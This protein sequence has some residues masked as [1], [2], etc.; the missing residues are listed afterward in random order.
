M[1]RE[2]SW[3]LQWAMR[4]WGLEQYNTN[5]GRNLIAVASQ[6]QPGG[7]IKSLSPF[8]F[9]IRN[10]LMAKLH[11]FVILFF[12]E[13]SEMF[14]QVHDKLF[15]PELALPSS[16]W[17]LWRLKTKFTIQ[18]CFT[19]KYFDIKNIMT[20]QIVIRVILKVKD[21]HLT[22]SLVWIEW[23]SES[24]GK[25]D[26]YLE[27]YNKRSK[28]LNHNK[29]N[30]PPTTKQLQKW[31]TSSVL[32]NQKLIQSGAPEKVVGW[33]KVHRQRNFNTVNIPTQQ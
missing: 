13:Y 18:I 8:L 16:H 20:N 12:T 30:C 28:P 23:I 22:K 24:T 6:R 10:C 4:S 2:I 19:K 32:W 11:R 17:A 29:E 31:Q 5:T 14:L 1:R 21:I 26:R 15:C 25:P 9:C 7:K 27:I 3:C 33:S